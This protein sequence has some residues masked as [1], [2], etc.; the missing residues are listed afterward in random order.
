MKIILSFIFLIGTLFSQIEKVNLVSKNETDVLM[1]DKGRLKVAIGNNGSIGDVKL[2]NADEYAYGYYDDITFLFAGGGYLSGYSNDTL[3]AN[4]FLTASRIFDY[5]PGKVGED[6]ADA[7]LKIYKLKKS[8]IDFGESWIEWKT[9]VELGAKFYD[10][11]NDGVYNPVDKNNNGKW[12]VDEDKPDLIGNETFWFVIND[13]VPKEERRFKV[14]PHG[15]EIRVTYFTSSNGIGEAF[16]NTIFIR[17]EI[18][19]TGL[20]DDKLEDV[21]FSLA[22]DADI[23]V[24]NE[25]LMGTYINGRSGFIYNKGEDGEYG[26]D[27][28]ASFVTL[29]EGPPIY[30]KGNS[31]NDIN[32]NGNYDEGIDLPLDTAYVK[33]GELLGEDI[34][35]GALNLISNSIVQYMKS[36]PEIGDPDDPTELRYYQYGGK[37]YNG[38]SLHISSWGFGNGSDLGADSNLFPFKYMYWG[39]PE[40]Q[41]GWINTVGFDQ[42]M[43]VTTGK[44][45]LEVGKPKTVLGAMVLA[46]GTTS[47]N[48]VTLGKE[49]VNEIISSYNKNFADISVSVKRDEDNLPLRFNLSQNY[50][51]PFNPTTT[52]EYTILNVET[53]RATSQ[54][55]NITLQVY[56]VLGREVAMLVNEQQS[57]GKYRIN[58]NASNLPSG[59]YFYRLQTSTGFLSTK[60]MLLIK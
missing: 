60:K 54:M 27:A 11:D 51:N 46:R 18:E 7:K 43:M 4:G 17:K 57:A 55:Q 36:H 37:G 50:P 33:H 6:P 45:D 2:P 42:R 38:D 40:S 5:Q 9:A 59:V 25:D 48:S 19:N 47:N 39:D 8:D 10:G 28:P 13:G 34:Y 53:L 1:I 14:D 58:F 16:N 15:I 49:Y 41:T 52:I 56:D 26:T 23:G 31:Y 22:Q 30:W 12:D 32:E 21:Y 35:P 44:F 3:W 20:V 29:L 24:Y